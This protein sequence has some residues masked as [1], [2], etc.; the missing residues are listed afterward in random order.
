M[1]FDTAFTRVLGNEGRLSLDPQDRG[2]WTS[3]RVGVGELKGTM[4]GIS[5]MS[6]PNEDIRNLTKE[7]AKEIYL[8]DFWNRIHADKLPDGVAFQAFDFAVNSSVETAIRKL[9]RAL[10]VA[11]DGDWGPVTSAAAERMS[12]CRIIMRYVAERLD[13][14]RS[15]SGWQ[16]NG[17]GWAGRAAQD[18]RYGAEDS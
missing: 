16:R 14:W 9:Q 17:K 1:D 3:G 11:D 15:L 18:L 2:N 10:G 4:F 13:Y 7:R 5:A 12:E 8:N 6:Y